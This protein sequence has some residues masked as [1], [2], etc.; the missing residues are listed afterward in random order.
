MYAVIRLEKRKGAAIS[1]IEKHNNR[2]TEILPDG[3]KKQWAENAD[4]NLTEKNITY[5]KYPSLNLNQSINQHLKEIGIEKIRKDAVKAVEILCTA[6]PE[7][8]HQK[9][10]DLRID[11]FRKKANAFIIEKYGKENVMTADLHLD[12][13]TPHIHYVIVPITKDK[14]LSAKIVCGNRKDYQNLQNEYAEKMKGLGLKRGIEGSNAKHIEMKE[15]YGTLKTN[16]TPMNEFLEKRKNKTDTKLKKD[17][18]TYK[19]IAN[20]AYALLQNM[21]YT[22]D[23]KTLSPRELTEEEIEKLKKKRQR[24]QG[25]QL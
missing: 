5:K 2:T 12:E 20:A 17:L 13:K 11:A 6:S 4:P 15:F 18:G 8:F 24:D 25:F 19:A 7:F 9:D 16:I 23:P 3:T 1:A 21:N 14:R 22:L 10:M